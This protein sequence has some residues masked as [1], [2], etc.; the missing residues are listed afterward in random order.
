[1]SQDLSHTS[2]SPLQGDAW[3]AWNASY[4]EEHREAYRALSNALYRQAW[5]ERI[6]ARF[7]ELDAQNARLDAMLRQQS[8]RLHAHPVA[9][10]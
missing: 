9:A 10:R 7:A 4:H 5:H 1:M 6:E 8:A 3:A 2:V